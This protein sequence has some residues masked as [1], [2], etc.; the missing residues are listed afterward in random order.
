[1]AL[2]EQKTLTQVTILAQQASVNVQWANRILRDG[3]LVAESY[4]R[5]AYSVDQKAEFLA[6][7]EGAE[8]YITAMGW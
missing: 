7:V 4:E 1:M 8:N 2:T 5:K 6:E 3:E